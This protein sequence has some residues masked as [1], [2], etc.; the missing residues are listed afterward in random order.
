MRFA[1]SSN[2]RRVGAPQG[3][4]PLRH[5][6]RSDHLGGLDDADAAAIRAL[7]ITRVL[8]FR[9]VAERSAAACRLREVTVY[10]LPIEPTIVQ[11]LSGL[12][13]SGHRLTAAD[14]TAQMQDTYR[15]FVRHNTPRF[16]YDRYHCEQCLVDATRVS[17]GRRVRD[18]RGRNRRQSDVLRTRWCVSGVYARSSVPLH[19]NGGN[20]IVAANQFTCHRRRNRLRH[21]RGRSGKPKSI[22]RLCGDTHGRKN[23][24]IHERWHEL[25]RRHGSRYL[26]DWRRHLS[27]PSTA[28]AG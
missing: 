11:K 12:I 19:G 18:S 7:G 3:G 13:A 10:S 8:D 22:V 1:S 14:V 24:Q 16:D 9:G 2:F 28:R 25:D 4:A 17:A 23:V 6:Y 21:H 15:G 27:T 20:G 26:D 5:L